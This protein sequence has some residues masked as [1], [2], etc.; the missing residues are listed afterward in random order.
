MYLYWVV[1]GEWI[2]DIIS[3]QKI[4]GLCGLKGHIMEIWLGV[5]EEIYID[6]IALTL[7][8]KFR[9]ETVCVKPELVV[10]QIMTFILHF[11]KIE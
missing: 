9:Q 7:C 3:F 4:L 10:E 1:V 8:R 11:L 5:V 2:V 6:E